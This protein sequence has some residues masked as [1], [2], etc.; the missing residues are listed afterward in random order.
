ME[1]QLDEARPMY[2]RIRSRIRM[3]KMH[4]R[5]VAALAGIEEKRFYRLMDGT[6]TLHA[7]E[8]EKLCNVPQLE[9]DP[10]ELLRPII[11]KN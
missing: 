4:F 6:S 2:E 7:E 8:V 11:L 9:L 3:K 1:Q 10:T 5:S